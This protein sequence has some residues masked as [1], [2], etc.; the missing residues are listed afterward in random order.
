MLES[1]AISHIG[2]VREHNEDTV[3]DDSERGFF[4]LADGVGGHGNG[5]LAS[6]LA[7]QTIERK[8]RQGHGLR[9]AVKA[10]DT[11]ILQAVQDDSD[12]HNMASTI[13][14]CRVDTSLK[15]N[16]CSYAFELTWVGDSRA[17]LC[18]VDGLE[19][20]TSDHLHTDGKALSQALGCLDLTEL[21]LVKGELAAGEVLL[22]CS[23]GLNSTLSEQLISEL[24]LANT[25]LDHLSEQLL[26]QALDHGAPDNVSYVLIR[27]EAH[28]IMAAS[29]ERKPFDIRAYERNSKLRPYFLV[30]IFLSI[31]FLFTVI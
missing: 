12:L 31:L 19:Q 26:S 13:V 1:K 22:L 5:Q 29:N 15:I 27:P 25:E 20:L 17:Y 28:V 30:M 7:V 24:C 3:L 14:A 16:A 10:A 4:L 21:P 6:S 18:R 11:A 9:A 8:L 2:N 23:D